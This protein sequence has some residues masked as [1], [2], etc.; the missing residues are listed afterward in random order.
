MIR[1]PAGKFKDQCL[2]ILDRVAE[3]KVPITITKR[4]RPVATLVPYVAT[5]A[6]TKSLAGSILKER[7]NPYR[8]GELWDADLP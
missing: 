6:V 4:G 7:G 2:K 3:Q 8:T 5:R 1:M